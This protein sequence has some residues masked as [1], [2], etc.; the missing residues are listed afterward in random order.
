MEKGTQTSI[1][2]NKRNFDKKPNE[3][4]D[5]IEEIIARINLEN[6]KN[7]NE[8]VERINTANTNNINRMFSLFKN[9]NN[10]TIFRLLKGM[11]YNV[12]IKDFQ[13]DD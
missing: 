9:E 4:I 10:R 7:I 1:I 5:Y 3:C 8:L 6:K 13:N 2:G 11:G 12:N